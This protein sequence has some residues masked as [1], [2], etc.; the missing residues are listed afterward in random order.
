MDDQ[1]SVDFEEELQQELENEMSASYDNLF[2]DDQDDG[3]D[4]HGETRSA[5]GVSTAAGNESE[6]FSDE[7]DDDGATDLFGDGSGTDSGS[8][9]LDLDFEDPPDTALPITNGTHK[10]D[11]DESIL[12]SSEDEFEAVDFDLDSFQAE[13]E[14]NLSGPTPTIESAPNAESGQRKR[15]RNCVH[16]GNIDLLERYKEEQPSLILHLFDSHFR[17]EGQEGVFLYNG[18]M[19]FF[20]DSLNEGKIP[21]DLVDVLTQVNCSYYD[22]CL[23]VEV[24]D[25][26]RPAQE[27]RSKKRRVSG[28]LTWPAYSEHTQEAQA[29]PEPGTAAINGMVADD[30]QGDKDAA[31]IVYKKVMRPT[32][33]TLSLDLAL[34]CEHSRSKLSQDDTL[35]VEGM[36][37]LAVEAPL[38]LDPDFQISR[39]SNAIRYIE[40]G[41]LLPRHTRKY[42]SAEIEAE[43]TEREEKLKLLTLMDDRSS[44]DFQPSFTRVSQVHDWRHRKCINDS[45]VYPS[46]APPPPP[47]KKAPKKSRSQMPMLSDGRKVIRT[48]RFVQTI[49]SRSIHTVFHVVELPDTRSLQGIM[50]WGT[51]PDTSINGGSKVFSFPNEEIMRMH[52]DNFKLLL[53]IEDN[54]LIYDSMYPNGQPTAGPPPSPAPISPPI[55]GTSATSAPSP[56]A[57]SVVMSPI[58]ATPASPIKSEPAKNK[59]SVAKGSARNSRKN[60]PQPKQTKKAAKAA[61][62]EPDSISVTAKSASPS[63]LSKETASR[64]TSPVSVASQESE[65]PLISTPVNGEPPVSAAKDKKTAA[66]KPGTKAARKTPK[67]KKPRGKSKAATAKNSARAA[68]SQPDSDTHQTPPVQDSSGAKG[69]EEDG[70]PLAQNFTT[71]ISRSNSEMPMSPVTVNSST[72]M[73]AQSPVPPSLGIGNASASIIQSAIAQVNAQIVSMAQAA[74]KSPPELPSHITKEYL[75]ANPYYGTLFRKQMTQI[76]LHHQQ[77]KQQQQQAGSLLSPQMRPNMPPNMAMF[78]QLMQNMQNSNA[79]TASPVGAPAQSAHSV[80]SN[81]SLQQGAPGLMSPIARPMNL[82]TAQN[83]MPPQLQQLQATKEDMILIQ[84]YCRLVG[85]QIQGLDDQRLPILVAKAKSGEL[86]NIVLTRLQAISSQQQQQQMGNASQSIATNGSPATSNQPQQPRGNVSAQNSPIAVNSLPPGVAGSPAQA[87][88]PGTPAATPMQ[89]PR[90]LANLPIH[91]KQRLLELIRQRQHNAAMNGVGPQMLRP[92]MPQQPTMSAAAAAAA[93]MQHQQRPTSMPAAQNS[94]VTSTS[95]SVS[96]PTQSVRPMQGAGSQPQPQPLAA[97]VGSPTPAAAAAP[98]QMSAAQQ[99]LFQ[100]AA[101]ANLTPQQR[102]ELISRFQ[103]MQQMQ[104]RQAHATTQA[105]QPT[106]PA[107]PAAAA[108]TMARP[109]Q[110]NVAS[111]LQQISSGHINPTALPPQ[112]IMYLLQN[113]QSQLSVDQRQILQRLLAHHIQTQ[114]NTI[115]AVRPGPTQ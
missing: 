39:V 19:R 109:P 37:L 15:K 82:P 1:N 31:S 34:A 91:E 79:A 3:S 24:H 49:G 108:A 53:S 73:P 58:T 7:D 2:S 50:R 103:Q 42:N 56:A 65:A 71:A 70:K 89:L 16:M 114:G 23:I 62:V 5:T 22:G 85:L 20:F 86:K 97:M 25:H 74:G 102:Q 64:H 27:S 60:S 76:A 67:E 8:E 38:D 92:G 61:S 75:Q 28:L 98:H 110:T 35:A 77:Q 14:G 72:P 113:A 18:P 115:G 93:I 40:Y 26:R 41:H 17:F 4:V 66:S 88:I 83:N 45:D 30:S 87:H 11:D 80:A 6:T 101:L 57:D 54:R 90:D 52:I 48:L 95:V 105:Q 33:E 111:I 9:E 55:T 68:S 21:V 69:D 12:S 29:L 112:L 104:A 63:V 43:Q 84:Q 44:R 99:Q 10:N 81:P 107:P 96:M 51:L 36:V 13:L 46:A 59:S 47:G 78:A 94:A 32:I 100:Q 106:P